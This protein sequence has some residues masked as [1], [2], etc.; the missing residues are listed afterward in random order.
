VLARV[1][2]SVGACRYRVDRAGGPFA[3]LAEAIIYQQLAGAA[4]ATIHRRFC[5]LAGRKRPRPADVARLQDTELRGAGLSR[6][7]IAYLRDLV[8]QVEAG[9]P[10]GRLSRLTDDE[11]VETLTA[12][13]GIGRWTA[14]MF[15]M[16]RLGRRDVLPVGDL[17]IRKAMQRAWRKR[18]LPG[19]EWMQK[20]AEPW[21]PYRSVACW[22]LWRSLEAKEPF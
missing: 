7:K 21:R 14:E 2:D 1:I 10:L 16:F 3:A 4:A 9:L 6:P 11:V 19:P 5:A 12:V 17:G 13:K 8:A 22:Y 20:T 18:T 15:L